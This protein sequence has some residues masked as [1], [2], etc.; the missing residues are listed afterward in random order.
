MIA[1]AKH[2]FTVFLLYLFIYG[3]PFRAFPI[4][5]STILSALFLAAYF[6]KRRVNPLALPTS[7]LAD[8]ILLSLIF[9]YTIFLSIIGDLQLGQL[10]FILILF[11]FTATLA[12]ATPNTHKDIDLNLYK[13]IQAAVFAGALT[14]ILFILPDVNTWVKFTLLKY[15]EEMMKYQLFRG[16]GVADELLYSYSI[17]Q[18]IAFYL[19]LHSNYTPLKKILF[20]GII[21]SSIVLN[22][23][24]GILFCALALLLYLLS[25]RSSIKAKSNI[26]AAT[27]ALLFIALSFLNETNTFVIQLTYLYNEVSG[28]T[29]SSPDSSS[30]NT[31]FNEMIFLPNTPWETIFGRGASVFGLNGQSSDSGWILM[32]HYGGAVLALLVF[33]Y[34][35]LLTFRLLKQKK[36]LLALFLFTLFVVANVKGLFFAP[37]PGMRMFLLAYFLSTYGVHKRVLR[38]FG[39]DQLKI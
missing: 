38:T 3:P 11:N 30:V 15:D 14:I 22:A 9:I 25:G 28:N 8:Y 37:K 10:F 27:T 7:Y 29:E 17:A 4:N 2:S 23:K 19:C 5:V 39:T 36:I 24:I 16:F 12:I 35:L 21:F 18:S 32:L 6:S 34:C 20:C 26:A 31:L 13:L 33:L 1:C